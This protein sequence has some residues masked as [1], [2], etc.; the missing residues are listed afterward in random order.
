MNAFLEWF[1]EDLGVNIVWFGGMLIGTIVSLI[2][3]KLHVSKLIPLLIMEFVVLL[4]ILDSFTTL[5][6]IML[7]TMGLWILPTS[8]KVNKVLGSSSNE[9]QTKD[10]ENKEE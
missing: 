4:R 8:L 3:L 5:G 1:L 9:E 2:L 6:I 10:T 7:V